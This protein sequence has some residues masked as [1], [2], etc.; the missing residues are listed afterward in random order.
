MG[1]LVDTALEIPNFEITQVPSDGSGDA[2]VNTQPGR[3]TIV[4]VRSVGLTLS[5]DAKGLQF[6]LIY[7]IREGSPDHTHLESRTKV[8]L[9]APRG[10]RIVKFGQGVTDVA[11]AKVFTG[12][13]HDFNDVSGE[14]QGSYLNSLEVKFD[15]K[16]DDDQGNA[17]LKASIVIP[18]TLEEVTE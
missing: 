17:R 7:S 2:D 1:K 10:S 8:V 6:T 3:N 5:P 12:R 13:N 14:V 18:V 4:T 16:G 15:G 11:F 9:P